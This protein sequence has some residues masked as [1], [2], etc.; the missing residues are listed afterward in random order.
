MKTLS[1]VLEKMDQVGG[2]FSDFRSVIE[3]SLLPTGT[4][5]RHRKVSGQII[6]SYHVE[7]NG[8]G[9]GPVVNVYYVTGNGDKIGFA[10]ENAEWK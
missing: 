5:L 7:E 1:E 8:T 9:I 2:D 4:I 3:K 6:E 10:R